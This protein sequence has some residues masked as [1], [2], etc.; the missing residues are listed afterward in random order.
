M[1]PVGV[2]GRM[3]GG[4]GMKIAEVKV[5]KT[6]CETTHLVPIPRGI[7]GAVV[8]I[9]YTDPAWDDERFADI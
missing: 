7:V 8:P 4:D 6:T 2:S 1:E 9:E 3:G 5:A